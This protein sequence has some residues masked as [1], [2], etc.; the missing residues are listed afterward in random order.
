MFSEF[1]DIKMFGVI[2]DAWGIELK[3]S[4]SA[5]LWESSGTVFLPGWGLQTRR[6]QRRNKH[7]F[8]MMEKIYKG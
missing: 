5:Y 1:N 8:K 4:V 6:K 7:E 2:W 3:G